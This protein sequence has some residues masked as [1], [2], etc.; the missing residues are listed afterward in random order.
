MRETLTDDDL[1]DEDYWD[2]RNSLI[3][4]GKLERARG[5]GGLVRR[6]LSVAE[7]P[8][9]PDSLVSAASD[10]SGAVTALVPVLLESSL[11]EPFQ[12]IIQ[13]GYVLDND[14]KPWICEITAAQGRRNTGGLWTR[15]DVTL[16]AEQ[17]FVYFPGKLFEVITFEIKPDIGTAMEGVYEAAAHSAFAHRSY[18]A[19]PDSD[20]Y[21][22]SPLFDR[23]RDECERFGL[24][25]ILFEDV[26][27]WDTYSFEVSAERKDPDPGSVNDFIKVQI[28]EKGRE[29]IQRWFR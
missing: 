9:V 20:E 18:L 22:K 6:V 15:P 13:T 14:L 17:T 28:S 1:T 24:G 16:I 29:E 7:V 11:Y 23:I 4:E 21:E 27:N 10:L 25:L 5:R 8:V 19:F 3:D 12:K 2:L 26:A